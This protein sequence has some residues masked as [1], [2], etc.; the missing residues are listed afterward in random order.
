MS[1]SIEIQNKNNTPTCNTGSEKPDD[2][3]T[4]TDNLESV[5]LNASETNVPVVNIWELRQQVKDAA[6]ALEKANKM[7]HDLSKLINSVSPVVTTNNSDETSSDGFKV[8]SRKK[9]VKKPYQ[10]T[11]HKNDQF[12]VNKTTSPTNTTLA[13]G[14]PKTYVAKYANNNKSAQDFA[15]RESKRKAFKIAQDIVIEECVKLF[16]GKT[17]D[18][19]NTGLQYMTSYKRTVFLKFESDIVCVDVDGE[20]F[21][22]SRIQFLGNRYFQ[23]NV[24]DLTD[25]LIPDAWLRFFP[26]REE[27]TYCIGV[28]KR[29]EQHYTSKNTTTNTSSSA[30]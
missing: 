24:R 8:F 21:E 7:N 25:V 28:Y 19:I 12:A 1:S 20:K 17:A 10:K 23:K 14:P 26:G 4:V 22:F 5:N 13:S 27:G 11:Y 29:K 2:V 15:Y 6:D 18:D 3:T 16:K 30:T 9:F